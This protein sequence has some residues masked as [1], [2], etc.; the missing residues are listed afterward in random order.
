MER[1]TDPGPGRARGKEVTDSVLSSTPRKQGQALDTFPVELKNHHD[2]R[3]VNSAPQREGL[4]RSH[5]TAEPRVDR[6]QDPDAA[7]LAQQQPQLGHH[8]AIS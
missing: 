5:W 2:T 4:A 7:P 3:T 6:P 1:R 8:L